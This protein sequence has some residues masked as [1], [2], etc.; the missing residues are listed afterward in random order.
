MRGFLLPGVGTDS[1]YVPN[2]SQES[3]SECVRSGRAVAGRKS[4]RRRDQGGDARPC[5]GHGAARA[6]CAAPSRKLRMP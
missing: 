5:I 3:R 4:G 2:M 6:R 1:G